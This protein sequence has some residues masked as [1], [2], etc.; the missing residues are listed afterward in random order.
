VLESGAAEE[1]SGGVNEAQ[2][3]NAIDVANSSVRR[4]LFI[5]TV[6]VMEVL[7]DLVLGPIKP[8]D[9]LN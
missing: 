3:E 5:I 4:M 6:S 2:A 7:N 8:M 9:R 1:E